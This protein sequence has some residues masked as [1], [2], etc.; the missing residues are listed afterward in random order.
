MAT[1]ERQ[2]RSSRGFLLSTP[3]Q[4]FEAE[5]IRAVSHEVID[6]SFGL[7]KVAFLT[8]PSI[9]AALFEALVWVTTPRASMWGLDALALAIPFAVIGT[10]V[11]LFSFKDSSLKPAKNFHSYQEEFDNASDKAESDKID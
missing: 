1:S 7:K 9:I 6:Q 3:P 4:R 8:V 5:G 11:V 2:R 10:I